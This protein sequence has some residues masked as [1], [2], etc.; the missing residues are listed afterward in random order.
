M[1]E[2]T[3]YPY[4]EL[5]KAIL[6]VLTRPGISYTD[7]EVAHMLN[8]NLRTVKSTRWAF[9]H[10][11]ENKT[12]RER[13]K[14]KLSI[15]RSAARRAVMRKRERELQE[16]LAAA[17][18]AAA[19]PQ[20]ELVFNPP[21][22]PIEL[23]PL[24]PEVIYVNTIEENKEVSKHRELRKEDMVNSPSHYTVGGIE[25]ID[26]IRA[27]LNR[28]EYI[29]YLRGNIFKYTSRLGMKGDI[30]QDAGKLAWYSSELTNFLNEVTNDGQ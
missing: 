25:T 20:L 9:M 8:C 26:Y 27:K 10:P 1:T 6:E 21:S 30:A 24:P 22:Q 23:I 3:Q 15:K 12:H 13:S 14:K 5:R 17:K 16:E 28:Q 2:Y 7:C 18:A 29:G 19:S 11:E 4:G